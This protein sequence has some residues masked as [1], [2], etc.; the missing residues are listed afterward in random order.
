MRKW[1]LKKKKN[2]I[3]TSFKRTCKMAK[4]EKCK[5]TKFLKESCQKNVVL[6]K[7]KKIAFFTV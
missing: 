4:N 1:P 6:M 2:H 3:S 5:K 7:T